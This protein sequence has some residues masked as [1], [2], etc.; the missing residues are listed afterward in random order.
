MATP[1]E[2]A[3]ARLPWAVAIIALAGTLWGWLGRAPRPTANW[4]YVTFGDALRPAT[5]APSMAL[6]PDGAS[7]VIKDRIQNGLLW[8]K[9]RGEL[10]A[11]PIPGTE[12]ALYPAFSPDGQWISFIA[13]AHLKKVRVGEGGVI[14]LADTVAAPFGGA[15]WL[16]DGSLVYVGPSLS[17]LSRVSGDGGPTS[18]VLKSSALAGLGLAL[19]SPLPGARGVLFSVCTSGCATVSVHLLDLHTG[20]ER[21]LLNDVVAAWYLPTGQLFFVRRDGAGLVA[22]FDLKR[23]QVTG[24][25]VPVLERVRILGRQPLLTLSRS[26]TLV[27]M[28]GNATA[29]E[30]EMVRVTREGAVVPVDTAWHGGFNSAALSPDGQRLAIGVGWQ[31]APSASGSSSSTR[32]RSPASPLRTG[33]AAGMVHRT[34]KPWRS[35]GTRSTPA[36]LRP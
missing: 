6:S 23:L 18:S 35:S 12:R 11:V 15:S 4:Q 2:R 19:P 13:D 26:G 5:N 25:A 16:E 29:T 1:R 20:Q 22:P 7:L 9:R 10:N 34:G 14:T 30:V 32:D 8:L 36:A 21:L 24:P 28:Q 33:P 3:L 27:F 17:E 31:A